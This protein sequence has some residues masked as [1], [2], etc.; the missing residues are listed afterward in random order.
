MATDRF[1]SRLGESDDYKREQLIARIE[2]VVEKMMLPE[3]EA[4]SYDLFTK[5]FL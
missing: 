4:L 5:G 1:T 3:L 2:R